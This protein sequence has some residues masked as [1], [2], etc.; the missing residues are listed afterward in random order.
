MRLLSALVIVVLLVACS[1]SE[2]PEVV[3]VDVE[4]LAV[5]VLNCQ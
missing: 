4:K 3:E 2:P 5:D 1:E